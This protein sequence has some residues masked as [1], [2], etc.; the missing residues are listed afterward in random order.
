MAINFLTPTIQSKGIVFTGATSTTLTLT[1][2]NGNLSNRIV[3]M[4]ATSAVNS[5]PVNGTSY[6]ANA[7][8]GSGTQI[9]TGNYV[10]KIGSGPLTVTA[11]TA[12]T[13]YYVAIFEFTGSGGTE[14]YTTTSPPQGIFN[15]FTTQYQAV[16]DQAVINGA[17]APSFAQRVIDNNLA[18]AINW[19]EMDV[20]YNFL[21]D[22]DE[23]FSLINW[24]TPASFLATKNST[25]AFTTTQGWQFGVSGYLNTNWTPSTQAVKY[26]QN[27]SCFSVWVDGASKIGHYSGSNSATTFLLIAPRESAGVAAAYLQTASS[28]TVTGLLPYEL[29]IHGQRTASAV[30]LTFVNGIQ[31]VI[32]AST[33]SGLS[34]RAVLLGARDNNTTIQD[35]DA[36]GIMRYAYGGS[37]VINGQDMYNYLRT[38]Y[39]ATMN[40]IAANPILTIGSFPDYITSSSWTDYVTALTAL[41]SLISPQTETLYKVPSFQ[42]VGAEGGVMAPN[43]W[44]YC[45]PQLGDGSLT[46][47]NT[48]T[49]ECVKIGS[50]FN[51]FLSGVVAGDF[52]YWIPFNTV[53]NYVLKLN[54]KTDSFSTF[55]LGTIPAATDQ[56]WI[57]GVLASNGKIYCSNHEIDKILVIDTQ[58]ADA[59]TFIT[60]YNGGSTWDAT[61]KKYAGCAVASTGK[62]I[63]CA[64]TATKFLEIDPATDLATEFG[65]I[66][67]GGA[68]WAGLVPAINGLLVGIAYTSPNMVE[69]DPVA[70][71]TTTYESLGGAVSKWGS[72]TLAL[73]GYEVVCFPQGETRIMIYNSTTHVSRFIAT[74]F[75]GAAKF[76]GS[77]QSPT[78]QIWGIPAQS[79]DLGI[80]FA[81]LPNKQVLPVGFYMSRF[82]NKY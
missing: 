6:T 15:T 30:A 2:T 52:I 56:K 66:L 26:T 32:R 69:I 81:P 22:G 50:G 63:F 25:A 62:V 14:A 27:S 55:G 67:A 70:H 9:G 7:A 51:G 79:P 57:S 20:F 28:A 82:I 35:F 59:I 47:I 40:N 5:N 33:S 4:K 77:V 49:R 42:T 13:T 72:G 19:A 39:Q 31:G 80:F 53:A 10:V 34:T 60:T 45:A 58:N 8:F 23:N 78:G 73:N 29:H 61:T 41:Q 46:K 36:T 74:T 38:H 17:T 18:A 16:L 37:S 75:T 43:G 12:N 64:F 68:K 24:K 54:W 1:W 44:I 76:V 21:T 48:Y 71:T 3:V 11:L 65:S